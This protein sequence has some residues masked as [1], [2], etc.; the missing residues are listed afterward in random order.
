M[1]KIS[2]VCVI[3]LFIAA[4]S[5]F[6]SCQNNSFEIVEITFETDENKVLQVGKGYVALSIY[7]KDGEEILKDVIV[8]YKK[9]ASVFDVTQFVAK[10]KKI[11]LEYKGVDPSYYVMGI[12]NLYEFDYG[13]KSG[14]L[15]RV[16]G[17]F[18]G[19]G[20]GKQIINDQDCIE[21]FYSTDLGRD[22]G[23]D[24]SE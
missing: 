22:I 12:D 19:S 18:I 7:G 15:F 16:N 24:F 21:W 11:Q 1:K 17:I 23:N 2:M 8:K 20:S 6:V 13:A 4:A 10:E 5:A 3:L 9:D 14:W